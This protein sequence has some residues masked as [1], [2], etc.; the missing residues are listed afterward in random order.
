MKSMDKEF[1]DHSRKSEIEC[2]F[3]DG[4][5]DKTKVMLKADN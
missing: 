5:Q 3:F 1:N 2:I 4:R